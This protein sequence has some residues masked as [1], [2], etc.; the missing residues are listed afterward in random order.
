MQEID[1]E[2]RER[3]EVLPNL[4][5]QSRAPATVKKYSGAL[6]HWKKW[7]A[8]KRE[9]GSSL[10]PKPIHIA[11]YLAFLTQRSKTSAPLMEAV[12]ALSWVN[13]M[14]IEDTTSHPLI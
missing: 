7:A 4:A 9:I 8:T 1:R 14:A 5:L 10:P 13:N 12:C 11:L 6:C 2:L 3:A